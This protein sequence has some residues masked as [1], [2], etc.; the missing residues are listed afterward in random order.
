MENQAVLINELKFMAIKNAEQLISN[1]DIRKINVTKEFWKEIDLMIANKEL[2]NMQLIGER[3]SGKSLTM[4]LIVDYINRKI[5]HPMS[6]KQIFA[7]QTEFADYVREK[8]PQDQCVGIDEWSTMS[9]TGSGATT[10]QAWL[11]YISDVMA[12][13]FVHRISCSP[14]TI[15]DS[16]ANIVLETIGK[17]VDRKITRA[18]CSYRIVKPEGEITQLVGYI[19]FF[20]GEIL[21]K[22][23]YIQ[24]RKK[25][26]KRMEMLNVHGIQNPRELGQAEVVREVYTEIREL[27][28][29]RPVT[30]P[31]VKAWLD[32]KKREK[33]Q[34]QSIIM[35]EEMTEKIIGLLTI[36]R[37]M[38]RAKEDSIK[39]GRKGNLGASMELEK[40]SKTYAEKMKLAIADLDAVIKIGKEYGSV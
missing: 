28:K 21:N 18:L 16:G 17:D 36:E 35:N 31:I 30:R 24:Y 5:K 37:E 15:V 6:I 7:D 10:E 23:W 40:V 32:M 12:Q 34:L 11:N 8:N 9:E 20:V 27:A 38:N 13:K 39:A 19:D 2:I 22:E 3:A 33:K 4:C 26:F 1:E 29:Y 25:K 14:S